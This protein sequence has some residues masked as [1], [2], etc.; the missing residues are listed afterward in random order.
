M[1]NIQHTIGAVCINRNL[2]SKLVLHT[3]AKM[4]CD[5]NV[6]ASVSMVSYF[7]KNFRKIVQ[8]RKKN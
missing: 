7:K 3:E 2:K 5:K 4:I 6:R 1:R 8:G